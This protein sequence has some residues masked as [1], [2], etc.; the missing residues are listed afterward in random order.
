MITNKCSRPE[1][2]SP[3]GDMEKL[4]FALAYG[5]DAVYLAGKHFGLR[6][7]SG[8]FTMDKLAEA[9]KIAHKQNAKVYV[10]ANIFAH[11]R[12]LIAIG[13]Y[14][15]DLRDI[16]PD[17]LIISDLGVVA[18]AKEFAPEIPIHISTQA[19][20]VNWRTVEMWRRLGANRIVL[21]RELTLEEIREIRQRVSIDLEI[22]VHGA[23]CM[24]YSGRC[25]LSNYFTGRDANRGACTHPCR[26]QYALV[27]SQRPGEYFPLEE[28]DR[29]SYIMNSKDLNL[30]EFMPKFF[31]IGIHSLKIEGR[32]KSPYYTAVTTKVYR[33]AVD[34]LMESQELF[35]EKL[36]YWQ[37]EL[38]KISHRQYCHGFL[39]GPPQSKDHRYDSSSYIR[40]YDFIAVV[41][42]Y[43]E[44]K[45]CL[46]LEQRNRFRVGDQIEILLPQGDYISQTIREIYN[47][48]WQSI[49]VAPHAQMVVY[50]PRS[51]PL[52]VM[53]ILRRKCNEH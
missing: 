31:E 21:G 3:A 46:V 16:E 18:L 12:D 49:D 47:E 14:F 53:S 6:A 40:T 33:E 37:R 32:M 50:L 1:I 26:W 11:N 43:D 48:E 2:L 8:N 22:F 45:R 17:G 34:A 42:G 38:D 51:Q 7:K 24:S 44:K 35:Q 52:P 41:R 9:V 29:G 23:M 36:P 27:E 39:E 5:A 4:Q 20:S 28:D 13:K 10:A 25:L 15:C 30:L 19:N